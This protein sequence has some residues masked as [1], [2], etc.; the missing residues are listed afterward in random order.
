MKKK[1]MKRARGKVKYLKSVD[2]IP[3]FKNIEEEIQFWKTHSMIDIIDQ[4][5]EV[6]LEISGEL[7]KRIEEKFKEEFLTKIA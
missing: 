5:P 4:F 1:I 2:E 6:K 3:D 7:K